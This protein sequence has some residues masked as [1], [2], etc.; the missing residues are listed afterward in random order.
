MIIIIILIQV[1]LIS[2][3]FGSTAFVTKLYN[4]IIKIKVLKSVKYCKYAQV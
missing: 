2:G 1:P 3:H 4:Y